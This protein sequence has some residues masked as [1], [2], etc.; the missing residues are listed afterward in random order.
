MEKFF[1]LGE[2]ITAAADCKMN[3]DV[4][5]KMWGS[6]C[7]N[8]SEIEFIKGEENTFQIG[9][10]P[11]PSLCEGEEFAL[12]VTED[13]CA[14]SARDFPSL[15]RGFLSLIMKIDCQNE[16]KIAV[17]T[18]ASRYLLERRMI[19]LCVAPEHDLY[20]LKKLIRAA[21]LCQY[22][23][24]VI[25]FWGMLKYDCLKELSW[26]HAFTKDEVKE[27]I[28]EARDLGLEPVPT[29][30]MFGH[31]TGSRI[32][33]GKH[34]VLEQN[35]SLQHLFTP[36]GWAWDITSSEVKKLLCK[37]RQ[38]LYEVFGE[39]EFIHVG[40]DEAY[41]Y[42]KCDSLRAHLPE[43]LSYLTSAVVKEGRRPM[44]WM[45]MI[46]ERDGLPNNYYAFGIK[47][48]A[49]KLISS[50][51][52]ETVMVDWQ[53]YATTVPYLS[54]EK[55]KESGFDIIVAPWF[56][57]KNFE[58]GIG[59]VK[60]LDL[61]ALMLTTWHTVAQNA[62]KILMVAHSMG[63]KTFYFSDFAEPRAE[64]ATL[65]RRVSFEGNDYESSGWVKS[66]FDV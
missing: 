13:G 61:F 30:N 33:S 14:V 63:A 47:D 66:Q 4:A 8:K 45:D 10:A 35:P 62:E 19:H 38:E 23:H 9:S 43:Y 51:A 64:M 50:L 44:L 55:L 46:L 21:A 41:Y 49:E 25:E 5:K 56:D 31:A 7:L 2:K 16:L 3:S 53:Y 12:C 59:T 15:M 11:L 40:C 29:F 58:A 22:T 37:V 24:V 17:Q 34:V 36:D 26:P 48:E 1:V 6:F 32:S 60:E 18:D 28:K 65:L 54:T 20:Y 39:G 42:T 57:K 27:V 52:K